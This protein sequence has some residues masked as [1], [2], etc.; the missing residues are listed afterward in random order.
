MR[1]RILDIEESKGKD[2]SRMLEVVGKGF[3]GVYIVSG[4]ILDGMSELY[5]L[6]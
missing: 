4:G 2:E 5:V 3:W 1:D 6:F